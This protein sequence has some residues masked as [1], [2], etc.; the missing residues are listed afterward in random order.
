MKKVADKEDRL[1][2]D[3]GN[4]YFT[5][6]GPFGLAVLRGIAEVAGV[7]TPTMDKVLTWMQSMMGKEYLKDGKLVGKD[8]GSTRSP[9]KYGLKTLNAMLGKK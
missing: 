9:Q 6:D 4:R 1:V 8:I 5:E 3:F 2:P 7:K